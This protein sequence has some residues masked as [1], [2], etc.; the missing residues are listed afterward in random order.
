MT[1][2]LEVGGT[3]LR[4]RVVG[5]VDLETA[6]ALAEACELARHHARK[7]AEV[8]E[9]VVDLRPVSFLGAA[10]LTELVH[11][12][13]R[14]L[15]DAVLLRVVADQPAVIRPLRLTGLDEMLTL[16]VDPNSPVPDRVSTTSP[17][18][19]TVPAGKEPS[20]ADPAPTRGRPA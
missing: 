13:H 9:I 2:Q 20:R 11:A 1:G 12:H 3:Q 7:V 18:H 10:G 14:C 6:P 4:I 5:E 8:T 15:Y 19:S 16:R 17:G